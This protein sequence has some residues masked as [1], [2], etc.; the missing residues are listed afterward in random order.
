MTSPQAIRGILFDK[1]GTL[2]DYYRTWVP[3]NRASALAAAE[4]DAVL[5]GRLLLLGGHDP[6]TDRIAPG[7]LLAAGITDEIAA[8]WAPE[9]PAASPWRE[10]TALIELLDG[11]FEEQGATHAAPVTDLAALF[12]RLK[13]RSLSLGIATNDGEAAAAATIARFGLAGHLDFLAGYDSGHGH[14]PGPGMVHA[15]CAATALSPAT[16]CVV[17]DNLHDLEM[18]RGAGAGLLVGVLTGSSPAE[19]LEPHA[20]LVLDSIEALEKVLDGCDLPVG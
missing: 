5:A 4:G 13:A 6:V 8:L 20:D 15:F 17:G 18:G 12:G 11:I 14:K 16:V 1:D 2:F 7:S 9:L 10:V 3:V 19:V